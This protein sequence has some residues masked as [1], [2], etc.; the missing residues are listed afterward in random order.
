MLWVVVGAVVVVVLLVV[1]LGLVGVLPIFSSSSP[2]S[3]LT[4]SQARP[5]ADSTAQGTSG[6]SWDL[7]IGAG[8]V[9]ATAV[10]ESLTG[11]GSSSGCVVTTLAGAPS[12]VSLPAGPANIT[13]GSSP[14][15]LFLYRNAAGELLIVT[16]LNG[17][18]TAL[19]TIA[20]GQSCST[21]FGLLSVVPSNVIDSS[22]AANDV[23]G[24]A[25]SF[26]AANPTVSRAYALLGGVSFLGHGYGAEWRVNYTTCPADAT[27][28]TTGA[29]FN[30][31]VNATTGAVIFDQTL[32]SVACRSGL[33]S[34]LSHSTTPIAP[35]VRT[36]TLPV[37]AA[38]RT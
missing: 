25:A 34:N 7:L 1:G 37:A 36:A 8:L 20:S 17:K 23:S 4:Y 38:R 27:T 35:L 31:T 9:S 29:A 6:G 10:T 18:G 19:A 22:A 11:T 30:A 15:W 3:V 12:N 2:G 14:S 16:V 32:S 13:G 24:D 33:L 21:V 26:L 5:I 28:G